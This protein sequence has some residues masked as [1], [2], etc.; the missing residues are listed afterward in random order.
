MPFGNGLDGEL[1]ERANLINQ[2]GAGR[3]LSDEARLGKGR[4][5]E[6][7]KDIGRPS[8]SKAKGMVDP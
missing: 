1:D 2:K 8:Q 5:K 4:W 7:E 3:T 6:R